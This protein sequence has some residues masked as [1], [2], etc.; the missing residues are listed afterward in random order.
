MKRR[1]F[2]TLLVFVFLLAVFAVIQLCGSCLV[3]AIPA[4]E[5]RPGPIKSKIAANSQEWWQQ[6]LTILKWAGTPQQTATGRLQTG[7]KMIFWERFS[8]EGSEE[9]LVY[10]LPNGDIY[11]QQTA[12]KNT[13]ETSWLIQSKHCTARYYDKRQEEW[14]TAQDPSYLEF[15]TLLFLDF[16]QLELILVPPL[17]YEPTEN[18]CLCSLSHQD[19]IVFVEHSGEGQWNVAISWP[20]HLK[21]NCVRYWW[22]LAS[23][24]ELIDWSNPVMSF[25]WSGYSFTDELRW[26]GDGLYQEAPTDYQPGGAGIYFLNPATYIPA[27]FILTGGSRAANDLGLIMLDIVSR[28]YTMEGYIPVSTASGWL[29]RDYGIGPGYFDTRWNTDLAQAY[30]IAGDKFQVPDFTRIALN[31]AAFLTK[32]I[33][34]Q[35]FSLPGMDGILPPDYDWFRPHVTPHAS[36]NHVLAEALFLYQ[37]QVPDYNSIADQLIVAVEEIGDKWILPDGNLQYGFCPDGSPVGIDYPY[38][39]YNDLYA[40]QAYY[41]SVGEAQSSILDRLMKSKRAWMDQQ[42]IAEYKK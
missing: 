24:H 30:L 7:G 21:K 19:G 41:N 13:P 4:S 38:L 6:S 20:R 42:G 28:K 16:D 12:D 2:C 33:Q 8:G 5:N 29:E 22:V 35:G 1:L 37:T 3:G 32:Y 26:C 36:L 27:R 25:L 34:E 17:A 23:S 10:H 15:S 14:V 18:G 31:Y 9:N 40:V 39:T 11:W